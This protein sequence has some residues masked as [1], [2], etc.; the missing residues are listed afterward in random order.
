M[1]TDEEWP[2]LQDALTE[3]IE[4][5]VREACNDPYEL[6]TRSA[7]RSRAALDAW[8]DQRKINRTGDDGTEFRPVADKPR[9]SQH[10]HWAVDPADGKT[11]WYPPAGVHSYTT[12]E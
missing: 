4:A 6:F 12:M 5:R 2:S 3:I 9:I 8:N 1:V 7:A 10:G 11:K